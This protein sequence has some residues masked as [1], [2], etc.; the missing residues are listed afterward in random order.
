MECAKCGKTLPEGVE[1]CSDCDKEEMEVMPEEKA[2]VETS[3]K[4][5]G[6]PLLY[7]I[8]GGAVALV[9]IIVIL[10]IAFC[11]GEVRLK[12]NMTMPQ[13]QEALEG[14]G[15]VIDEE[16][17]FG[18]DGDSD[19]K[20][21][22]C[23]RRFYGYVDDLGPVCLEIEFSE[24]GKLAGVRIEAVSQEALERLLTKKIGKYEL[25][26]LETSRYDEGDDD[27]FNV[28]TYRDARVISVINPYYAKIYF[29][30]GDSK[31]G[32]D[33]LEEDIEEIREQ[34]RKR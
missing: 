9:A 7:G 12:P 16:H 30:E 19:G 26:K 21:V 15:F 17:L 23:E 27:F 3:P 24:T 6:K 4:K 13:V 8:I 20:F 10:C 31:Y 5:I 1:V 14:A 2:D 11:G 25:Y 34:G 29:F 18:S 22:S 33:Y 28:A 32:I